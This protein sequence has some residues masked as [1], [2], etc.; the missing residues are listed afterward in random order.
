MMK[1]VKWDKEKPRWS[2]LPWREVRQI[3]EVVS[4]G[5]TK[6]EDFNWQRVKPFKDRYLSAMMRHLE[7][8]FSGELK[9]PETGYYHLAHAGCC[10]LFLLWG[11]N[12]KEKS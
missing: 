11:E 6:Y 8:Y 12:E 7:A 10:L 9:D 1:G 4:Y 5:S 3:V 2:L